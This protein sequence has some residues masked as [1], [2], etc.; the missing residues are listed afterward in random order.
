M[1]V[2]VAQTAEALV[3]RAAMEGTHLII[4]GAHV[5]PGFVDLAPWAERIL[6]V[7]L[8]VTIEEEDLHER[9]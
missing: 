4:E 6:A 1:S 7:P 5:V 2:H 9:P 3:E 8:V